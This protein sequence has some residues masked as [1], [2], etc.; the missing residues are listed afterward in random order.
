MTTDAGYGRGLAYLRQQ[1]EAHPRNE[2]RMMSFWPSP[3]EIA[4]F[5]WM[6]APEDF[7][8][9]L[10]HGV[11]R[12]KRGGGTYTADVLCS[13]K[14]YDEP[15]E[16]CE[17]CVAGAK[18]PWYRTCGYIWIEKIYHKFPPQDGKGA[19]WKVVNRQ[20]TDQKLWVEEVNAP[21]F[22]SMKDAMSEQVES[23]YLGD[24]D[25]TARVPTLF[26]RPYRVDVTGEGSTR[27]DN[28]KGLEP[29]EMPQ[30]VKDAR[31]AM[32][33][34]EETVQDKMGERKVKASN[35]GGGAPETFYDDGDPG[36]PE[37]TADDDELITFEN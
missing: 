2:N 25:D 37:P 18:G 19:D 24:I 22:W 11:D 5:W 15:K 30:A 13:R 10:I 8:I 12:P 34:L 21:R 26:D 27:R 33:P 31:A 35:G 20:G 6:T 9:V 29:K 28:L 1:R 14:S 23:A 32:A 16:N 17:Y 7:L 36:P 4:Q 3:R